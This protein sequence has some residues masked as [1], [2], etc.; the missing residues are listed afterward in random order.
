MQRPRT[1]NFRRHGVPKAA[2]G[3]LGQQ[4]GI[5]NSGSVDDTAY[6]RGAVGVPLGDKRLHRVARAHVE[7]HRIHRDPARFQRPDGGD[8]VPRVGV[9]GAVPVA[10]RW[11]RRAAGQYQSTRAAV[12][13]PTRCQQTERTHAAGDQ[14]GSIRAAPQRLADRFTGDRRQDL[15]EEVAVAQR[16][17]GLG[18]CPQD[19]GRAAIPNQRGLRRPPRRPGRPTAVAARRG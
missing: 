7:A 8:L 11:Q 14:V 4:L 5:G 1:G 15:G 2:L 19:R 13:E 12:R 16:Q 18:R 17:D 3:D 10:T 6:R 9:G